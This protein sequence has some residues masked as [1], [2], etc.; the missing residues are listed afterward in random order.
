MFSENSSFF[1]WNFKLIFIEGRQFYSMLPNN[2]YLFISTLCIFILCVFLFAMKRN[3]HFIFW[4][5]FMSPWLLQLSGAQ[6]FFWNFI[7][8]LLFQQFFIVLFVRFLSHYLLATLNSFVVFCFGAHSFIPWTTNHHHLECSVHHCPALNQ[9][10]CI[11]TISTHSKS[12]AKLSIQQC[13]KFLAV[14]V[15]VIT[16]ALITTATSSR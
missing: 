3:S 11:T 13:P 2:F 1:F 15:I 6:L 12:A 10:W 4:I 5:A 8:S 9:Y 14:V 7:Y 16:I